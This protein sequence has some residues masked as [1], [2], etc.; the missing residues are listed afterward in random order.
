MPRLLNDKPVVK[1]LTYDITA[2]SE[3]CFPPLP[4]N[5]LRIELILADDE[6]GFFNDFSKPRMR[7]SLTSPSAWT[8]PT[9]RRHWMPICSWSTV[10]ML[11]ISSTALEPY[12]GPFAVPMTKATC[13]NY[14]ETRVDEE[15]LTA[16]DLQNL[17]EPAWE[18]LVAYRPRSRPLPEEFMTATVDYFESD[19]DITTDAFDW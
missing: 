14:D 15:N 11:R 18:G 8:T 9:C 10:R 12:N 7:L 3:K 1:V 19:E 16:L 4:R 5:R 2:F 17:T 13:A 6:E